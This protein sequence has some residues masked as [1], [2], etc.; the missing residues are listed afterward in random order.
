MQIR[1]NIIKGAAVS[2]MAAALL[3]GSVAS[4][5]WIANG[6][7]S[8]DVPGGEMADLQV[9][10]VAVT[11]DGLL[12]TQ[13]ADLRFRLKNLNPVAVRGVAKANTPAIVTSSIPGCEDHLQVAAGTTSSHAYV[14]ERFEAGEAKNFVVEDAVSIS[15]SSPD[16]CEGADYT[17]KI[18]TSA[19]SAE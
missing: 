1:R 12:P 13:T 2:G 11:T 19:T 5:A 15:N 9:T 10:N 4:A 18:Q 8:F 14:D 17:V 3:A 7:F 6:N 16:S